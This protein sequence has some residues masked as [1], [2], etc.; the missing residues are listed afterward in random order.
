MGFKTQD[1]IY[2]KL[3]ECAPSAFL[4]TVPFHRHKD[5]VISDGPTRMRYKLGPR[6]NWMFTGREYFDLFM[7]PI[8]D[9]LKSVSFYIECFDID[10]Y[11]LPEKRREQKRRTTSRRKG[12]AKAKAEGK[13]ERVKYSDNVDI[14][15]G[16]IRLENGFVSQFDIRSITTSSAL[17]RKANIFITEMLILEPLP[18]GT[19]VILDFLES[20]PI[21]FIRQPNTLQNISFRLNKMQHLFG[22]AEP[23]MVMWARVFST[24]WDTKTVL[25]R[26]RCRS[27]DS[28]MLQW[29]GSLVENTGLFN[30]AEDKEPKCPILFER[31]KI[32]RTG[33]AKKPA[34]GE[35]PLPK[36]HP[37][38]HVN[39]LVGVLAQAGIHFWM[40][41]VLFNAFGSDWCEKNNLTNGCGFSSAWP[42]FLA[43]KDRFKEIKFTTGD[44]IKR[45]K[46]TIWERVLRHPDI[47]GQPLVYYAGE[48]KAPEPTTEFKCDDAQ[49]DKSVDVVLSFCRNLPRHKTATLEASIAGCAD[50]FFA[51]QYQQFPWSIIRVRPPSAF[52]E[53]EDTDMDTSS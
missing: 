45:G 23:Q 42:T 2:A 44:L 19:S 25:P 51:M 12:E 49:F 28:D 36:T 17:R 20:G 8:R 43:F 10:S 52:L 46:T 7:A 35:P 30:S 40:L 26:I 38:V 34:A 18:V 1:E 41:A 50:L 48:S 33:K 27:T 13:E 21:Q 16:G 3:R 39:E 31:G 32:A 9:A 14:C 37:I 53:K 22:E 15:E 4:E 47:H 5:V 6:Y 24:K 29:L 11:G